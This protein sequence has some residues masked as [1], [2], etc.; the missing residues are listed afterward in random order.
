VA[1]RKTA[2]AQTHCSADGC[3]A[4]SIILQP[5]IVSHELHVRVGL[6]SMHNE[7]WEAFAKKQAISLRT[8]DRDSQMVAWAVDAALASTVDRER[9][10]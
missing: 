1:P 5:L 10:P 3:D 4:K 7:L 6:C 2:H 9:H 8:A